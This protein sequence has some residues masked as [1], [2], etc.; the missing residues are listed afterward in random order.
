MKTARRAPTGMAAPPRSLG[1]LFRP[2][3]YTRRDA[4]NEAINP[5]VV[6]SPGREL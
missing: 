5:P 3:P 4:F 2:C 1:T 6:R